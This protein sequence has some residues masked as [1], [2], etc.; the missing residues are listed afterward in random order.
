MTGWFQ[1]NRNTLDFDFEKLCSVCLSNIH[2]YGC[3]VCGKYFQ[4]RGKNSYA[5]AH[6]VAEDHHVFI[7]LETGKVSLSCPY[8][9][10]DLTVTSS[11]LRSTGRLSGP[12]SLIR[13]HWRCPQSN[14][15]LAKHRTSFLA[16]P[17]QRTRFRPQQQT[18]H[19]RLHRSQQH[20][21]Q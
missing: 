16:S 18:L 6:S 13:R 20:Q 4:G 14:I 9:R 12:R 5:F 11:G 10:S 19:S 15:Y 2:V 21:T 3:L 8:S 17:L 1:V 7:N